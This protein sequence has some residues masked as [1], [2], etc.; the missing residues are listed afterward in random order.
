MRK[1]AFEMTG[2]SLIDYLNQLR[3]E[4]A[5]RML[6][7]TTLSISQIALEVGYMNVQSF[8][9]F[10]RKFE[11]MPPSSYKSAKSRPLDM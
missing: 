6:V 4:Q 10:F 1:I 11:G 9:R 7:E 3:I 5:K 8:N 2:M